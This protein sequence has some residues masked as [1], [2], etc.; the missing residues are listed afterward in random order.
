MPPIVALKRTLVQAVKTVK[1]MVTSV[2]GMRERE[3]GQN[4]LRLHHS[5]G[6]LSVTMRAT[7]AQAAR[8]ESGGRR[9]AGSVHCG[10]TLVLVGL[11]TLLVDA[12]K[13]NIPKHTD[14]TEFVIQ[15]FYICLGL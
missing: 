13:A 9:V 15:G 8:A 10:K 5:Q 12:F 4:R 3:E 14:T 7:P 2:E 11:L 1:R 6:N